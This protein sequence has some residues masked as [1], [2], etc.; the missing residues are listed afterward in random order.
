[1]IA[2]GILVITAAW[3]V[4]CTKPPVPRPTTDKTG[5]GGWAIE[6][7]EPGAEAS[8]GVEPPQQQGPRADDGHDGAP[9]ANDDDARAPVDTDEGGVTFEPRGQSGSAARKP[10]VPVDHPQHG[11]LEGEGLANDCKRDGECFADGCAR[12]VCSAQRGVTTTCET[13][14]VALPTD[15]ACGCVEGECVWWSRSGT[16]LPLPER[17]ASRPNSGESPRKGA[18]VCDGRTCKPGQQCIEYYGIAGTSGPRFES[19]EW[20]CGKGQPCPKGTAC[21]TISDGPGRV[22]R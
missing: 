3:A 16:T 10:I 14:P 11:R 9:A 13:T 4:G 2:R 1:V 21:T 8:V 15:A 5:P 7:V 12:E 19:C 22:C 18:Q 6:G 17:D 20:P